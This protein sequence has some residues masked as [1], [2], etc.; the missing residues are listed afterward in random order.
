[1]WGHGSN[2]EVKCDQPTWELLHPVFMEIQLMP[3]HW[4]SIFLYDKYHFFLGFIK[5]FRVYKFFSSFY[6]LKR[7]NIFVKILSVGPGDVVEQEDTG[8]FSWPT[9]NW[10]NELPETFMNCNFPNELV[11]CVFWA[12]G[13]CF[14]NRSS[15][16]IIRGRPLICITLSYRTRGNN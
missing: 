4:I 5:I 7:M 1:M 6:W 11:Q 10:K 12:R 16:W 13:S 8:T 3:R 14:H 2:S 15:N 9:W